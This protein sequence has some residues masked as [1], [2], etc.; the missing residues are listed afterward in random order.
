MRDFISFLKPISRS[1]FSYIRKKDGSPVMDALVHWRNATLAKRRAKKPRPSPPA[2][3]EVQSSAEEPSTSKQANGNAI[4][5][6][7]TPQIEPAGE[8]ESP[9]EPVTTKSTS[10][11]WVQWWKSSRRNQSN[12]DAITV[13]YLAWIVREIYSFCP[14]LKGR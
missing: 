9:P 10:S 5:E 11:S 12:G 4:R 2:S 13:R 14:Q 6:S 3:S 8:V 1:F 7:V